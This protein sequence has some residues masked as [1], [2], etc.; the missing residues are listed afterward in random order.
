MQQE[1]EPTAREAPHLGKDPAMAA[2]LLYNQLWL[3]S[4]T[5]YYPADPAAWGGGDA[6]AAGLGGF[7][8]QPGNGG[9]A[10]NWAP[11]RQV[12]PA[13]AP[14]ARPRMMQRLRVLHSSLP[15]LTVQQWRV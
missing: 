3:S 13:S 14:H 15:T 4:G 2:D 11:A 7:G 9:R 8:M 1:W 12:C 5:G 10:H 6:A